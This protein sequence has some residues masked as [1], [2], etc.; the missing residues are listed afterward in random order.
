LTGEVSVKTILVAI[1]VVACSPSLFAQQVADTTFFPVVQNPAYPAGA[2][3]VVVIDAAHH[4][5]HTL[6]GRFLA[7]GRVLRGDGFVVRSSDAPFSASSLAGAE[8]LVISNA[9][10][11]RNVEDWSL[12]TPS[13]FSA[14]EIAAVQEWVESGGSLW[15]IADHMPMPGAASDV[16]SAFGFEF[17][18]GFAFD[19]LS[20][21][22]TI[23]RRSDGSLRD[24]P[25]TRGRG[26]GERI[27]SIRTF[28]GQEF[29]ADSGILPLFVFRRPTISLMPDVAWEFDTNTKVSPVHGWYQAAVAQ[30]GRGRVAAF[31]EAA[32]FTAQWAGADN[33]W[34]GLRSPGAEQNQQFLLNVAHWLSGLMP[35]R[36]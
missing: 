1:V 12:P 31:G 3:P 23:F 9:L 6:D 22:V 25:I 28:T 15:L 5:F 11:E 7:F 14:D 30:V 18:N 29:Q 8:I 4:N 32:M 20:R 27:D 19:T 17:N 36:Q 16:A 10:N 26:A 13:A 35:D 2:G 24:H 34:F 33:G 21:D